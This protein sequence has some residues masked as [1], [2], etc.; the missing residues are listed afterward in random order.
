MEK[1]ITIQQE[2]ISGNLNKHNDR[3]GVKSY[4][5]FFNEDYDLQIIYT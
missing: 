5:V 3:I 1:D 4:S 2:D